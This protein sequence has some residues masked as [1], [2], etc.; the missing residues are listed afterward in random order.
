MSELYPVMLTRDE[1]ADVADLVVAHWYELY[2][3]DEELGGS[4]LR[5]RILTALLAVAYPERVQ[6]ETPEQ[7]EAPTPE[8]PFKRRRLIA[9]QSAEWVATTS[10]GVVRNYGG[11][12]ENALY[13]AYCQSG[14]LNFKDWLD[15]LEKEPDGID[16]LY[17]IPEVTP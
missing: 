2:T 14:A 8:K 17:V 4:N 10:V 15:S 5:N 11:E 16:Y 3:P 1:A 12:T 7:K 6:V 9:R 13:D